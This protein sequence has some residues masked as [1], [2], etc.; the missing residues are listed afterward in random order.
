MSVNLPR[1]YRMV[2]AICSSCL[3][4][5]T[6]SAVSTV[7]INGQACNSTQP[8]SV[9]TSATVTNLTIPQ[10]CLGGQNNNSCSAAPTISSFTPVAGQVGQVITITGSNF[11]AGA[12]VAV[13]GVAATNVSVLSATSIRATVASGTTS[14]PVTVN[15]TVAPAATSSQP[16]VVSFNP[17]ITSITPPNAAPGAGV[18]I[19]GSLIGSAGATTLTF[20]GV[21][22]TITSITTNAVTAFVPSSLTP[23]TTASV[24]ITANGLPSSPF[25]YAL[26]GGAIGDLTIEGD[27]IPTPSRSA[28][29]LTPSPFRQGK[30]NGGGPYL[31][32]YAAADVATKCANATPAISRLWQ[33]NISFP[34]YA[35]SGG[36]DYPIL[37]PGEAMAWKFVAPAE[38]VANQFQYNEGTQAS[39]QP[40]YMT[41]SSN[42]CDFDVTKVYRGAAGGDTCYRS[43]AYGI[44]VYYRA[45]NSPSTVL[46]Y[47]CRL[48]PGAT[49]YLNLRMQDARPASVGGLPTQDSCLSSGNAACGGF[50]QI[51]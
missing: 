36:N 1:I 27:V 3:L 5:S 32:A 50:V 10:E 44:S 25:S 13:N 26:G 21:A 31:N 34:G 12:A 20:N 48:T 24:V 28:G 4:V 8:W 18:Q 47:E 40:G 42:P 7:T 51:R 19:N 45:T 17:L 15:T 22:A 30:L 14:G 46:L 2:L 11:C 39:F 38:G 9:S 16:F 23:G 29:G 49:Y 41:I 43:E 37:G 35:A 6:A 33:H